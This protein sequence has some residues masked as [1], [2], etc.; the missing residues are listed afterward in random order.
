MFIGRDCFPTPEAGRART[1]TQTME[2]SGFPMSP[3]TFKWSQA[4][5][6]QCLSARGLI[7]IIKVELVYRAAPQKCKAR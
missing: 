7:A 4:A 3:S 6:T 5:F 1:V 2:S